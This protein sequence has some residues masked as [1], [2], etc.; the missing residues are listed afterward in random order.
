[1]TQNKDAGASLWAGE[2]GIVIELKSVKGYD[3]NAAL[4]GRVPKMGGFGGNPR[5]GELEI[6][7]PG[8]IAPESIS[9][10]GIVV[11]DPNTL[12]Q[13]VQWINKK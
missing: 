13:S 9:R 8:A 12:T 10:I 6:A 7:V 5:P 2:G 3:V 1:L 4:E 11:V